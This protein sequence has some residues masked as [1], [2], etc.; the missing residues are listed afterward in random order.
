MAAASMPPPTDIDRMA[1]EQI[2]RGLGFQLG[3]IKATRLGLML[4]HIVEQATAEEAK[5]DPMLSHVHDICCRARQ[6]ADNATEA[7]VAVP[8]VR[9]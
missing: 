9:S 2:A 5:I 3:P 1:L 6:A 8:G 7:R 4:L